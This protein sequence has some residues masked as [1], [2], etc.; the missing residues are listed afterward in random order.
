MEP[1]RSHLV[2]A[3]RVFCRYK[4]VTASPARILE[5]LSRMQKGKKWMRE[6]RTTLGRISKVINNAPQRA[7]GLKDIHAIIRLPDIHAQCHICVLPYDTEST[8]SG[9][10]EQPEYQLGLSATK[11]KSGGGACSRAVAY[12]EGISCRC[13]DRHT[14]T[15]HAQKLLHQ[16][17]S[18]Q[19][20]FVAFTLPA[21]RMRHGTS[22]WN[23]HM[24]TV[25]REG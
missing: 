20:R 19:I 16:M 14:Y 18:Y 15:L 4:D 17:P 23:A 8:Q 12:T 6:R 13:C 21:D 9:S 24:A 7:R 25:R 1:Q 3:A 10:T 22:K 5:K 11:T 2:F